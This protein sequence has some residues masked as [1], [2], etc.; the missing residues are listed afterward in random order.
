MFN[1]NQ[2]DDNSYDDSELTADER[3]RKELEAQQSTAFTTPVAPQTQLTAQPLPQMAPQQQPAVPSVPVASQQPTTPIIPQLSNAGQTIDNAEFTRQNESNNNYNIG[4]HYKPNTQGQRPSTAY[5]P[6]GL[7]AGAVKDIQAANPALAKPIEQWTPEEHD[8]AFNTLQQVNSK[9]LTH[10]GIEPTP[11]NLR[12]AHYAGA[13]GLAHYLKTGE[14]LAGADANIIQ[15]RLAGTPS[16]SSGAVQSINPSAQSTAPMEAPTEQISQPT[17]LQLSQDRFQQIQNNPQELMNFAYDESQ[18]KY[19]RNRAREHLTDQLNQQQQLDQAQKKLAGLDSKGVAKAASGGLGDWLQYL[20]YKHVGLN[21]LANEKGEQLGIGHKWATAMNAAGDTG[22]IKY[23][24][25]GRPISGTTSTGEEMTPEQL[26]Q[27]AAQGVGKTEDVSL[28]MHQAVVDGNLHTIESKRTPNG[29]MY[30]DATTNGAWTRQAPAG[31]MN[32]GQQSPEH[33]RGISA[34]NTIMNKMRKD[35]QAIELATGKPKYTEEEIQQAGNQA[36]QGLTGKPLSIMTAN[37]PTPTANA[38]TPSIPASSPT[39]APTSAPTAAPT[40][41]PTSAPTAA[42]TAAPT[43]QKS[44]AEKILD[45]D[46]PPPPPS[47]RDAGSVAL[48]NEVNRLAAEKGVTYNA[49]QYKIANKTKQDFTTGKQG[50]AVQSMNVAIDHLDTLNEAGRALN[51]GQIP[52]FNSISNKFSKESG[53]PEITDFNALKSIVGSEV[54]KAVTGGANAFGDREEIR[55]EINA[56]N[57][58]AQLLGV[59]EKY[60]KLMAGQVKGLKQTY[61]SAGL[62]GFDDKLLPRTKFVLNSLE[63]PTRRKWK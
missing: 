51:N 43:T 37:A 6:Y 2:T 28:T 34:A 39:A 26:T 36:Y 52:L 60:Q 18:P 4:Y 25:S 22:I 62:K 24:A 58:P 55:A 59:I 31:M 40:A 44:L 8:A 20:L 57:S 14:T 16:P 47:A 12:A 15:Q 56:A 1:Y 19:L 48:R 9:Y 54:A 11:E 5:G 30:R 45:Y 46:E 13:G 38:P 41:A 35:N 49:G 7:T 29:L 10:L 42:P 17:A 23:S 21:D 32:V 50:Q 61:E 33:T 63:P 27:Y 53:N 3:R